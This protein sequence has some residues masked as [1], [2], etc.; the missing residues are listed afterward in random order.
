MSQPQ[1][2]IARLLVA[3]AAAVGTAALAVPA[4]AAVSHAHTWTKTESYSVTGGKL[5]IHPDSDSGCTG[6]E[7]QGNMEGCVYIQGQGSTINW[8]HGV[9]TATNDG[10]NFNVFIFNQS[11]SGRHLGSDSGYG[12]TAQG[13]SRTAKW[14]PNATE[15]T[16]NYCVGVQVQGAPGFLQECQPVTSG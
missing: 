6:G 12:Y 3:V 5:T 16:G 7:N 15:P 4:N 9:G 13:G 8:I 10:E 2:K 1:R 11:N 14:T